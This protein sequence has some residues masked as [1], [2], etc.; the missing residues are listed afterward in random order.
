MFGNGALIGTK[1]IHR[2][3]LLIQQV[4]QVVSIVLVEE[5]VINVDP[6]FVDL[7]IVLGLAL[8]VIMMT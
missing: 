1:I 5:L 3:L 8:R 7:Q 6:S 4:H 2:I